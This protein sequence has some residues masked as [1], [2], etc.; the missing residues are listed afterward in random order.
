M[1]NPSIPAVMEGIPHHPYIPNNPI[2]D[3]NGHSRHPST[4]DQS[5][6]F[7]H[8]SK[9]TTHTCRHG[10]HSHHRRLHRVSPQVG[11]H[12]VVPLSQEAR[13]LQVSLKKKQQ[14]GERG[15]EAGFGA[16]R[17]YSWTHILITHILLQILLAVRFETG[18]GAL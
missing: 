8:K 7:L 16:P 11:R 3:I 17:L 6:P 4:P 2:P 15:G 1:Y 5:Q 12:L 14:R 18:M 13:P 10:G 9:N